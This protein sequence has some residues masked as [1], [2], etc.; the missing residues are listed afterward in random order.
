MGKLRIT[1]FLLV[2]IN[3]TYGQQIDQGGVYESPTILNSHILQEKREI[4]IYLPAGYDQSEKKYPVLYIIDAQRYF[5]NGITFQKNLSWQEIVP[6]FIVVGIPTDAEHRRTLFYGE[7]PK[8][9]EFLKK[10]L[11]PEIDSKFR[12]LNERIYFGWEMAAGLGLEIL[13]EEPNLFQSYLLASPT[14]ISKERLQGINQRLKNHSN[15]PTEIYAV[16]GTVEN[17]AVDSMFSLDSIFKVHRTKNIRWKYSLTETENHYTTPLTTINEGLKSIFSDY[18]PIRFYSLEEFA[19]Y[20]GIIKLKDHYR[21]RGEKYQVSEDIHADTIHYLLQQALKENNFNRF[22]VFMKEF[23]GN[24]FI[25]NYYR[26]PRWFD[27]FANYYLENDKLDE[28]IEILTLGLQKFPNASILHFSKGNCFKAMGK[29]KKA[30]EW[31]GKA[32][33]IARTNNEP[34]LEQYKKVLKEIN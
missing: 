21:K 31:Y 4:Q 16:L 1:I 27:R 24:K 19:V 22:E 18:G 9:I 14:H 2:F 15:Q 13:A 32:V 23:D 5:F 29:K 34:S 6:E 33:Q 10:E 11:I 12:T 3:N 28:S 25:K 8:F 17:W 30:K 26:Q 20:G 7:S